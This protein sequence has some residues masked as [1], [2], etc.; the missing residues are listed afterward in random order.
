M[1]SLYIHIPFCS[2]ICSYCDFHREVANTQ[3]KKAYIEAL[4]QEILYVKPRLTH[5]KTIYIGGGT[6]TALSEALLEDLLHFLQIHLPMENIQEFTIEANPKDIHLKEVALFKKY[7]INRVS[8]GAQTFDNSLLA[9]LKRNHESS[10]IIHAIDRLNQVGI[11]NISLDMIFALPKQSLYMLKK[12][13]KRLINLKIAHVSYYALI[14]EPQTRLY[15]TVQKGH[16]HLPDEEVEA[17]MYETIMA[18]LKRHGFQQYEVSSF[19][20]QRPSLHNTLIWKDGDYLGVGTG[21]HSKYGN[22]RYFNK[23]RIKPY[24]EHMQTPTMPPRETYPYEAKRDFLLMGMRLLEGIDLT[25]YQKRFNQ[26]LFED[27]P[28]LKALLAQGFLVLKNNH[29][30]LNHKGLMVGNEIFKLF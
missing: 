20:K 23:P 11:D 28:R 22:I 5:L 26:D 4:K 1:E 17:T 21:A 19:S 30:A 2:Q 15:H 27:Y 14:L 24:L 13:L 25:T 29:L 10:D 7:H 12:D 18:Y 9:M 3:K 8:L 6:P 16:Q